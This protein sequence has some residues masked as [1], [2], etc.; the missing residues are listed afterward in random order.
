M[1]QSIK[2]L[3]IFL[4]LINSSGI[5]SQ[6]KTDM[7]K[8]LWIVDS[9]VSADGESKQYEEWKIVDDNLIAGSSKTVKNGE[10]NFSEKLKI[11]KTTEG[12]FY[13]ADVKH[14]QGP[15][16]F[17]LIEVS[18]S[19]AVF[20]NPEHDFPRKITYLLENGNLHAFI[21]GPGKDGQNKKIDFY[22]IKMR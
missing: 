15:V 17:K 8:L 5:M 13:I 16:K 4:F 9:W 10:V 2:Y 7:E 1:K 22:L 20:E 12:I 6:G 14:N 11:E 3:L 19:I 21:E 18:D